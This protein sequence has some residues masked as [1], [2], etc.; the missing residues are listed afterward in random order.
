V[1]AVTGGKQGLLRTLIDEW[2]T[3]PVVAEARER[4]DKLDDPAEILR[5]LAALTRGMRQEYGD[6]MRVVIA[7]APHQT[8]A[9]EGLA[10]ATARYRGFD[11][12]VAQRLAELGALRVGVDADEALDIL[13]FYF[14]YAGFFTLVD[15]NGWSYAKAEQWLCAAASQALLRSGCSAGR[16]AAPAIS[17]TSGT[18]D[19]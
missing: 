14:G 13:W 15:D 5:F 12:F 10:T 4:I 1:Y 2:S 6:I 7:A 19:V 17:D 16:S 18:G 3:A 9:A 11:A 8:T